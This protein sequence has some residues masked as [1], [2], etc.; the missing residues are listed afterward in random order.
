MKFFI[1]SFFIILFLVFASSCKQEAGDGGLA[2]LHGKVYSYD[3]NNF[4]LVTDSGYLAETRV[5]LSYGNHTWADNNTR[6]SYTGEYIF[7]YLHTGDYSVWVVNFCDT[8][9]LN[10]SYDIQHV[11]IDNPRETVEVSDLINYF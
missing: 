1:N 5:Y 3:L 7:P 10:Q 8:C 6:T 11:T 9:S 2:T 4:G